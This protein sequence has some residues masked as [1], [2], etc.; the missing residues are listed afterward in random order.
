MPLGK[1]LTVFFVQS[2]F[3]CTIFSVPCLKKESQRHCF[4]GSE[5]INVAPSN[6]L[7]NSDTEH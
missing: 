5:K 7:L 4:H 3:K 1:I 2:L 6:T